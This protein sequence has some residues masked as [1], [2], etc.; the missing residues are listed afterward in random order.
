MQAIFV[1]DDL[2]EQ[3]RLM[4]DKTGKTL[5]QCVHFGLEWFLEEVESRL[6]TDHSDALYKEFQQ[7]GEPGIPWQQVKSKINATHGL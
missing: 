3:F 1:P 6:D 7:S 2:A 4:A 5:E